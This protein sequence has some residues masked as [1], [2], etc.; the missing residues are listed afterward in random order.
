MP[1]KHIGETNILKTTGQRMMITGYKNDQDI[2]VTVYISDLP[3][4]DDTIEV[5]HVSYKDFLFGDLGI[6]LSHL[7]ET[8]TTKKGQTLAVT[9]FRR[10][11]I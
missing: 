11:Q 5:S 9:T 6:D 1:H 2:T 7:G 10:L 3:D 4:T 8:S